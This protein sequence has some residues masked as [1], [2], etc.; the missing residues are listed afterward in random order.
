MGLGEDAGKKAAIEVHQMVDGAL[1]IVEKILLE[2]LQGIHDGIQELRTVVVEG[3]GTVERASGTVFAS[4]S[5]L[6]GQIGDILD[7][8]TIEYEGKFTIK[9]KVIK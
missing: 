8:M 4:V 3:T 7:G 6:P 2:L 9:R 5:Q 1:P